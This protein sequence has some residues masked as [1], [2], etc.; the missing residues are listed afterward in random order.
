ML[1]YV[2]MVECAHGRMVTQGVIYLQ[3]SA[4]YHS[5]QT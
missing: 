1:I 5:T 4:V 3:H 2:N